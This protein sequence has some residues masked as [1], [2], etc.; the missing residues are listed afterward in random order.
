MGLKI[1]I[2]TFFTLCL[3]FVLWTSRANEPC[4]SDNHQKLSRILM[5]RGLTDAEL[6]RFCQSDSFK[7]DAGPDFITW[8][9]EQEAFIANTYS[10][11]RLELLQGAKEYDI[12]E[13]LID[14][15][16]I[17]W[18]EGNYEYASREFNRLE[19]LY[20]VGDSYRSGAI[21]LRDVQ[22]W[23]LDNYLYDQVNMGVDNFV[24][25]VFQ[26]MTGRAPTDH[27]LSEG[28]KMCGG[29][30]TELFFISGNS[31]EDFLDILTRND[32]Y[33][34]YQVAYWFERL[35]F[36]RPSAVEALDVMDKVRTIAAESRIEGII[37]TVLLNY[38]EL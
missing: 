18:Q 30:E 14:F 6:A 27:E 17:K 23:L 33:L 12:V 15:E 19:R 11:V 35:L 13:A 25:T 28:K 21:R 20:H 38:W 36:R 29:Q 31:R 32:N 37:E 7:V 5:G 10:Q 22:I 4:Q 16:Q 1:S 24:V 34:E 9:M 3:V 8:V 2:R 26:Y